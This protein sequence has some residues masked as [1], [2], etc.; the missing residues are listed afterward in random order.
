MFSIGGKKCPV[1]LLKFYLSKR[2]ET[3][4]E[5]GR[6]YLSEKKSFNV[7]DDVWYT[8]NPMGKNS[9]SGIMKA[10]TV[11]TELEGSGK[12]FT[13]HSMRKTTVKKLK[14]ANISESSIIK[15]TGHSTV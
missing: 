11:G 9:I 3:M 10:L 4:K 15:V 1:R 13:N 14:A 7:N 8:K 6:F 12:K 2:P 5:S